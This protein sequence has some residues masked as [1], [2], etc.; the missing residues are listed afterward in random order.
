VDTHSFQERFLSSLLE[1][2]EG[3][4]A[5]RLDAPEEAEISYFM[6]LFPL[7]DSFRFRARHYG[8][9]IAVQLIDESG[10]L[11]K[12]RLSEL[13]REFDEGFY[14]IGPKREGDALIFEH[15][16]SSLNYLQEVPECAL[17]LKKFSPPLCH[18]RAEQA[19]RETLG[20]GGESAEGGQIRRLES[21]HVRRAVLAAWLTLLRQS[22]GSCFATAP[23]ILI[24]KNYPL[25]LLKDLYELLSTG[26]LKRV[27]GGQEYMVPMSL[28]SGRGDLQ[29]P[30]SALQGLAYSPGLI[31]AFEAGG[32]LDKKKT[33]AGKRAELQRF[34]AEETF[35][36]IKTVEELIRS[37]LLRKA[38]ITQEDLD[39]EAY[40][41]RI[42][43]APL[44]A[45][46]SAVYY[47]KP[48]ERSQKISAW[49][50]SFEQA[51][52]VFQSFTECALLRIWEYTI[53]SF[54][55]V[56]ID[57]ARWNLY[58]GLGFAHDEKGGIG[59][60]LYQTISFLLQQANDE[61]AQCHK[62]YEQAV[63][64]ARSG[65]S[66]LASS[67]NNAL[68]NQLR[69][70]LVAA[71]QAAN[72]ALEARDLAAA[73][74]E[75][76]AGFFSSLMKQYDEKLQEY[77]Q[78][79]FDPSLVGE[80]AHLYDD[81]LAGFRLVYKHGRSDASQWTRVY[82]GEE[83]IHSL[84]DFF[85]A[86]EN[87]LIV[88]PSLDRKLASEI[89][90]GLIQFIQSSEFLESAMRRSQKRGRRSPWDY[91]SGGTMETLLQAYCSKERGFEESQ[92]IPHSEEQLLRFLLE[93]KKG[94][95]GSV[96][97]MRS[98]THAFLFD[99]SLLSLNAEMAIEEIRRF[100]SRLKYDEAMQEHIAHRLSERLALEEQSLFLH[101]FRQMQTADTTA[102]FRAHLI[103]SLQSLK[104]SRVKNI[105][106]WVDSVLFEN[107]PLLPVSEAKKA[108]QKVI[109]NVLGRIPSIEKGISS[110]LNPAEIHQAVLSFVLEETRS[111]VSVRDWQRE[112]ANAMRTLDF[113]PPAPLL[114]ADTNWSGWFFGFLPNPATG[115]L[116]LWRFNRI[117]T[118]GAPMAD[119]KEWLSGS[120]SSPWVVLSN[121]KE[122]AFL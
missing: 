12:K 33:F 119:W 23:A 46:Q 100:F 36:E 28:E 81:S 94:G 71:V 13:S 60:F 7:Q 59:D 52:L 39:D 98:P 16:R 79:I 34:F 107:A 102:G 61:A 49:R 17:W 82:S 3:S 111:P 113:C 30:L 114:F 9:K 77:F 78:E 121:P 47:Q 89:T 37:V 31:R 25:R 26:R 116:E 63:N 24:Q 104:S 38:G 95:K 120:N 55:D 106:S 19:V 110:Y 72:A 90:T 76:L 73:K 57:F 44:L 109:E 122:L 14:F 97:L 80:E 93:E 54:C 21:F 69:A 29:K 50:K 20:D 74:A 58:I 15:L 87:D 22:T 6:D 45:R 53:A 103:E 4:L 68:R 115:E 86:V 43:M 40:L 70:E 84:R 101:R 67:D 65:E 2:P 1:M 64:A 66:M 27:F 56:K 5:R 10:E 75:A 96:L 41:A 92:I 88:P 91:F 35:D 18:K 99:P 117:G 118:Q 8:L 32:A 48:S 105:I 62:E 11:D 42:Q 108:I 85:A 112:I 51:C 83:Y